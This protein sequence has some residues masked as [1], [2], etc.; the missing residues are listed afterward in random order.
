MEILA[1]TFFQGP[2]RHVLRPA[3]AAEVDL[4]HY[5][6]EPSTTRPW[7]SAQ[8]LDLL[9][10]LCEHHCSR[11]HRGGFVERLQ[12]GTYAGHV[13]EHVALETLYLCGERGVYGK[14]RVVAGSRVL[15]VFETETRE[16]GEHALTL[17]MGLVESLWDGVETTM[18]AALASLRE[19]LGRHRLGPSTRALVDAAE[20]LDVPVTRLD[21]QNYLRLGQGVRQR[22]LMAS[23]TDATNILAVEVAQDK[24]Q[25]ASVLESAGLPVPWHAH[26][27]NYGEALEHLQKVSGPFV[28]KPLRGHH[29]EGVVMNITSEEDMAHAFHAVGQYAPDN[30]LL[31][32]QISGTAYRLLVVGDEVVAATERLVPCIVGDGKRTVRELVDSL[33]TDPRRGADHAYPMSYVVWDEEMRRTLH[34]QNVTSE[35][36]IPV[37]SEVRLRSTANMSTGAS[38]RDVTDQIAIP[39]ARDAVRAAH[40]IG[41]D[42]AGI[43]LVTTRLDRALIDSGGSIIEV[44]AAPGLRMHLYPT[45]GQARPVAEAIVR[46]LYPQHNG[47][48]PVAA[49]TGTNGKTTVTRM[50]GHIMG[51]MGSRVGMATTDGI[52]IAGDTIKTGDFTGP[53]SARLILNDPTVEVAVLETARGGMARAGLG[54]DDVDVA[55]VTNIGCDHLGQ[56]GIETLEDLIHLK[57]LLVDVVRPSGTAVLNA[58]DP[59]V[60]QMRKRCRGEV[61]LFSTEAD[62]PAIIEHR[63]SGGR[64]VYLKYGYLYYGEGQEET[65]LVGARALPASMGGVARINVANAAAAAS[66]ALVMGVSP[67]DVAEGL[68][69]FPVG[70][71]GL[72]R[73]RLEMITGCDLRVL[74]DYGHNYPALTALGEICRR[75]RP[76]SIVTVLGLPGDRRDD[77]IAASARVVAGFSHAVILREDDDRRGRSPGEVAA[78]MRR[79]IDESR[80]LPEAK[81]S[82]VLDE[83]EA[84]REAIRNAPQDSLVL[85]LYEN[86]HRV[87]EASESALKARD[88]AMGQMTDEEE[89][90]T[91]E[92]S[93]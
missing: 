86:Y 70:G 3:L 68:K 57:A 18:A 91:K 45:A 10:G 42:I 43:D 78:L 33:N 1:S 60:L 64:A 20:K 87:R 6:E 46:H 21:H 41:L 85:V 63:Q 39:L 47:R 69:T 82:V 75:L 12:E 7:V 50:L 81:V 32:Q 48:I 55:V 93:A 79:A 65:R 22:R 51:R 74:V 5:G 31:E 2:N 15:I 52:T 84:V 8:L 37:G 59:N 17:A 71:A 90:K 77:D 44:N 9:P 26:V 89:V 61:I 36:V 25:T 72:N 11:G 19:V 13:V 76:R 35:D 54:M 80:V 67:R 29:G 49:V 23:M 83:G 73:G 66:A 30:L 53:W 58:D 4:G 56:D 14:T 38:A 27:Q 16:G 24:C 34:A 88:Q 62:N 40:A 92:F 28:L